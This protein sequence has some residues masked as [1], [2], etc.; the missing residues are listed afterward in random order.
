[1]NGSIEMNDKG[2]SYLVFAAGTVLGVL[3][4]GMLGVNTVY[5]FSPVLKIAIF[6][7][8]SLFLALLGTEVDKP[9]DYSLYI[10]SFTSFVITLNLALS[11]SGI[12]TSTHLL[13]AALGSVVF[14]GTG[15]ALQK[16]FIRPQKNN[17]KV[18][19]LIVLGVLVLVSTYDVM[20][21]QPRYTFIPFDTPE[22][23][24][25][26]DLEIGKVT[27]YNRFSFPRIVEQP[28]YSACIYDSTG[29]LG[30]V[31]VQIENTQLIEGKD[32]LGFEAFTK[33]DNELAEN[34]SVQ[35]MKVLKTSKCISE[36]ASNQIRVVASES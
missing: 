27:A 28:E 7:L 35:Q 26:G 22:A 6:S 1:V 20:G 30:E 9:L 17:L 16:E 21:P 4:I 11:I 15:Y 31:P 36:N 8:T 2:Q 3:T 24:K 34:L 10:L 5:Q 32:L 25:R 23:D 12:T 29:Y 14:L 13:I 18:Y 33:I 19:L